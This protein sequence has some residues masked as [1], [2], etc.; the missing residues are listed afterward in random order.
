MGFYTDISKSS[1]SAENTA[2]YTQNYA[3]DDYRIASTI[4]NAAP[5][6]LGSLTTL[7]GRCLNGSNSQK[8]ESS[9]SQKEE[10][11]TKL[12]VALNDLGIT[13]VS[14][15]DSVLQQAEKDAS[16]AI[17]SA[18]KNLD[19]FTQG[20]DS[21]SQQ[22]LE[23]QD[24]LANL[25]DENDPNGVQRNQ[26]SQQIE[27]KKILRDSAKVK[28]Q[29]ELN[30]TVETENAKIAEIKNKINEIK[31]LE[32]QIQEFDIETK[33]VE[34]QTSQLTSFNNQYKKFTTS[35]TKENAELLKD[36]FENYS[37]ESPYYKNISKL[38][39]LQK[40]K[41]EELLKS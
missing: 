35:P 9:S 27:D 10:I 41:I 23:L 17:A 3:N 19:T 32:K 39:S 2:L 28:A 6:V 22:I 16:A 8:E 37:K 5:G 30:K 11:S 14:Q 25:N 40:E 12:A 31:N 36:I 34:S 1:Y 15:A 7:I 13:D 24:S 29:E 4:A 20:N 33:N 38:Y 21:F 26:I 18:E